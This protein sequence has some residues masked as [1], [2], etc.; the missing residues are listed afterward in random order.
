[1]KDGPAF[2]T[3]GETG[4]NRRPSTTGMSLRD[5]FAGHALNALVSLQRGTTSSEVD[6]EIDRRGGLTVLHARTAYEYADAMLAER[7]K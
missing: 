6:R 5:Y 1:M 4:A 3:T 7:A 2:P